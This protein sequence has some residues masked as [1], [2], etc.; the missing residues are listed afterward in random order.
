MLVNSILWGDS[1]GTSGAEIYNDSSSTPSIIFSDVQWAS[2]IY[3]GTGN[4]NVDPQFVAPITATFAPTTT[5]NYR[6]RYGSPVIDAGNNLSV[7][8]ATDL[9]G[10]PRV[11][12]TAVDLGA[13]RRSSFDRRN[14]G[15]GQR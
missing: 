13:Y 15:D 7:T 14:G 9:D 10:Y 11:R 3:T 5:G 12:D 6:L 1:A 2:G 4:L 8:V